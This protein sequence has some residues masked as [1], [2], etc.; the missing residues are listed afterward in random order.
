MWLKWESGPPNASATEARNKLSFSFIS[1]VTDTGGREFV[2][3][4]AT[5]TDAGTKF[6]EKLLPPS[7]QSE[8]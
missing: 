1:L 6:S 8:I 4:T 7:S 2:V 5:K 3:F